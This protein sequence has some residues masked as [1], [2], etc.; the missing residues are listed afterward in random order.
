MK[1]RNYL[2][3]HG[4]PNR[5]LG[6]THPVIKQIAAAAGISRHHAHRIALGHVYASKR[7]A[8]IIHT[9]TRGRVPPKETMNAR[10]QKP[11]RK[12]K[13]KPGAARPR[14]TRRGPAQEP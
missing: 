4:P 8:E 14:R 2:F 13:P 1:L 5:V 11:G 10:P 9:I 6:M 12:P 3:L 7:V